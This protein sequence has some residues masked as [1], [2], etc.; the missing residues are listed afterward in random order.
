[1]TIRQAVNADVLPG[2]WHIP[3]GTIL[4]LSLGPMMRYDD[5]IF[6]VSSFLGG[7]GKGEGKPYE[8]FEANVKLAVRGTGIP[9]LITV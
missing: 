3:A 8:K 2:G 1:M 5:V 9:L 4:F 6:T 7:R